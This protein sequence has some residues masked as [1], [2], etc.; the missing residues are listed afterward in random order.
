M[1]HITCVAVKAK[2][3]IVA[4]AWNQTPVIQ[5]IAKHFTD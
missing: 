4:F 2:R 3:K 1:G 5:V